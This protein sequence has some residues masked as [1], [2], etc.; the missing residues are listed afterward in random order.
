MKYIGTSLG[1]CLRSIL[2]GEVSEEDVI[3]IITRTSSKT[4]DQFLQIVTK[5][6]EYGNFTS[7]NPDRY[8]LQKYPYDDVISLAQRLYEGGKIHQPRNF[9]G[10]PGKHN[11]L[12]SDFG[13]VWMHIVPTNENATP[14]V[15]EAY[16]KYKLLHALTK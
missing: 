13:G 12:P 11:F 15:V 3:L 6:Y 5:Y 7:S 4:Y 10:D 16:E 2:A 14:A 1:G 9:T 8:M